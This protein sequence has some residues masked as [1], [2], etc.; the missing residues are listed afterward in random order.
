MRRRRSGILVRLFN[1][2]Y[3]AAAGISIYALCTRPILN[4]NVHV[5][6]TKEQIGGV[7]SKAFGGSSESSESEERLV[8]RETRKKEVKDFIT[9]E[10]VEGYFPNG[11]DVDLPL[12]ITAK[13]AFAINNKQLI[14]DLIQINLGKIVDNVY[15]SLQKPIENLFKTI[16]QEFAV[17]TLSEEINKQI[18]EYFPDGAPATEEEVQKVFDNVY[19]LL[20]GDE[21]VT[22][23]QLAD[24]ILHGKDGDNSGVLD[25]INSRGSKYVA[26]DPQPTEEEVTA[27]LSAAEGEE[28]YYVKVDG[29]KHNTS[30]YK[31]TTT[32][33]AQ[34]SPD[35]FEACDPQPTQEE[36]EADRNAEEGHEIF[37]VYSPS[38]V[39]NENPYDAS[40]TYYKKTPYTS[41]DIDD[42][43]IADMMTDSLESVEGLVT[44]VPHICD[45]QPTQEEVEADIAKENENDRIYYVLNENGDPVLPTEYNS[46]AV[47][48]TVEKVVND[49]ETAM[50]ALIDSFLNGGGN[51]NRAVVRAE[52][53]LESSNEPKSISEN[54]KAYL[55]NMIPEN[56]SA[57]LGVVG[58]KAPFIL[59]AIIAIFALPWAWFALVTFVR[60]LRGTKC[61]TRP[62]I[63]L[64]W[65]FPQ[66]IFGI[67]LTY[68][69]NYIFPFL[70]EKVTALQDYA[71]AFNFNIRTGCLIPSF[72]Y[73][74]VAAMTLVYWVI[75]RPMKVQYKYE[76][77]YGNLYSTRSPR[78]PRPPRAPKPP[79]PKYKRGEPRVP[80]PAYL[81]LLDDEVFKKRPKRKKG[82]PRQPKP[83]PEKLPR[84]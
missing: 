70:A 78:P 12:Q 14:D 8:Y 65:C 75:R 3:I 84:Y 36:V 81:Y 55:Y 46:S 38:Y 67:G 62:M 58:E 51:Q 34:T 83:Q 28:Q 37:F 63:V 10:K 57:K 45:P 77:R 76:S 47:Y 40:V 41:E 52:D 31:D 22:V 61:W 15:N 27:D 72:V 79:R 19:S 17:D 33:Y 30:E 50:T 23:D 6:L 71:E 48:Y 53:A 73:L 5:H 7:L 80:N 1:L 69:M 4:S 18:A 13:Q 21:P 2:V 35:V 32:Y 24:T 82:E 44:K 25:I 66:L 74:G 60:T 64:F 29:Y 9:K 11:Y 26:W 20:D 16:V 42:Q 68:G 39:H 43:K 54:I 49:L 59:L 56:V